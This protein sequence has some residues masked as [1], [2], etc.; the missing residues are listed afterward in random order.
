MEFLA[1]QPRKSRLCAKHAKIAAEKI[2]RGS[3]RPRKL[4][5]YRLLNICEAALQKYLFRP[6]RDAS[7]GADQSGMMMTQETLNLIGGA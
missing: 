7:L 3:A 2:A 1:E 5:Q 6:L 4:T